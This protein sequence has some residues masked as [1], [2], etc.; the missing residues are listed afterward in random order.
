MVGSDT[1]G[2][3]S[4]GVANGGV[5]LIAGTGSNALLAN[6]DGKTHSC[7]GWGYMM[8][9]EGSGKRTEKEQRK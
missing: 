7:G 5:V 8:G 6:P 1:V 4:T 3:I 9:D 2:S